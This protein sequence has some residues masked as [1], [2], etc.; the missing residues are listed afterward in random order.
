VDRAQFILS[1]KLKVIMWF[2]FRELS[3]FLLTI[4]CSRQNLA[5]AARPVP[6]GQPQTQPTEE[7]RQHI[8]AQCKD[9]TLFSCR[10]RR[11]SPLA[12][13]PQRNLRL[14]QLLSRLSMILRIPLHLKSRS[15]TIP[16]WRRSFPW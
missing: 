16:P 14:I 9:I 13:T 7:L 1:H 8:G 3:W 6:E 12:F 15:S 2:R 11:L 10:Q 5:S 4:W